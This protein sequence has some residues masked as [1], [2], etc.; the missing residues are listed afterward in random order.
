LNIPEFED[1]LHRVTTRSRAGIAAQSA[2]N[3]VIFPA[4]MPPTRGLLPL[5]E[6]GSGTNFV[7]GR[8]R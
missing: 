3:S 1:L 6:R 7:I 4:C 2:V 5:A 8:K